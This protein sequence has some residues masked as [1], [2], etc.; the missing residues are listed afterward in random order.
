MVA[1]HGPWAHS[2]VSP[3]AGQEAAGSR[4][5]GGTV[6]VSERVG[7]ASAGALVCPVPSAHCDGMAR[8][9]LP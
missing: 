3:A 1:P 7:E 2:S 6:V 5:W 8:V 9:T 4:A